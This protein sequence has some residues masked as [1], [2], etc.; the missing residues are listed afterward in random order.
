MFENTDFLRVNAET[1]HF[2][3]KYIFTYNNYTLI[4]LLSRAKSQFRHAEGQ[5]LHSDQTLIGDLLLLLLLL[6]LLEFACKV[7]FAA[8]APALAEMG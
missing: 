1:S 6:L 4:C 7:V 8:F 3:K 5:K 2:T